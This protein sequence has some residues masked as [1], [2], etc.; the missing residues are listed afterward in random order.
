MSLSN[1]DDFYKIISSEHDIKQDTRIIYDMFSSYF[2][3]AVTKDLNKEKTIEN[4]TE[5][6]LRHCVNS[7]SIRFIPKGQEMPKVLS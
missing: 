5:K 3:Y 7:L 1:M 6:N 2:I 4:L